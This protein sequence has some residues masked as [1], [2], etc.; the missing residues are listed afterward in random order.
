MHKEPLSLFS[1][2]GSPKDLLIFS[3]VVGSMIGA[4]F[5]ISF[6]IICIMSSNKKPNCRLLTIDI[7]S[8][9]LGFWSTLVTSGGKEQWKKQRRTNLKI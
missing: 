8:N 4:F 2:L 1:Y 9:Q 5:K 3:S 6:P 7:P